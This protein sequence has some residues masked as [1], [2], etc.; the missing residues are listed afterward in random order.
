MF[1]YSVVMSYRLKGRPNNVVQLPTEYKADEQRAAERAREIE[2]R[3]RHKR[4]RGAALLVGGLLL[5][6]LVVEGAVQFTK[7]A[8]K[9]PVVKKT[10]QEASRLGNIQRNNEAVA[11]DNKVFVFHENVRWRKTPDMLDPNHD[12]PELSNEAG[13]VGKGQ[14]LIVV[15][16]MQ[17]AVDSNADG[18][19]AFRMVKDLNNDKNVSSGSPKE[20]GKD[21]MW[22]DLDELK[23]QSTPEGGSF[24]DTYIP[25]SGPK[26]PKTLTAHITSN[27]DILLDSNQKP[28]A[29]GQLM[30]QEQANEFLQG[31]QPDLR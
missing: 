22:I 28:A 9:N 8:F 25:N 5:A 13:Q 23:Q 30:S 2:A 26:T 19:E 1:C 24:Y 27:G 31:Y 29:L 15:R 12:T 7:N 3:L 20:L 14:V 6:S 17:G 18:W 21:L 10:E 16:D 4:N 11:V